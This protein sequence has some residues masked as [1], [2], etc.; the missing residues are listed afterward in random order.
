MWTPRLEQITPA[1]V[2]VPTR[3]GATARS[4]ARFRPPV[5]I[6]AVSSQATCQG[7]QFSY[8]VYPVYEPDHPEDW[9]AWTMAWLKCPRTCRPASSC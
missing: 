6:V 8:G 2:F 3:S 1:A 5:W 4:I 9:K 7:L